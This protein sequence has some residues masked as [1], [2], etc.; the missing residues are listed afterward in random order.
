[1]KIVFD[2]RWV[3]VDVRKHNNALYF[4]ISNYSLGL[5]RAL[6]KLHPVTAL[7]CDKRQLELLP[8]GIDYVLTRNPSSWQEFLLPFKLNKLGADVVF[9]PVKGMVSFGRRYKLMLTIHDLIP[10][11]HRTVPER[12]NKFAQLLWRLFH[13]GYALQR[14]LLARADYVITVSQ[15]AKDELLHYSVTNRPIGVVPNAPHSTAPSAVL[16]RP[17]KT[18][19][20][21]GSFSSY[22][23]VELLMRAMAHLPEYRLVLASYITPR[24]RTELEQLA[25][26]KKQVVFLGG[27]KQEAYN[28]LLASS[29]AL[30]SAS[31]AE[32]FGLPV[33]EAMAQNVPVV[34]SD[35]PIFHEVAG[36]AGTYFDPDAPA[37]FAKAVRTLEDAAVRHRHI[38]AGSYQA[39]KFSWNASAQKLLAIMQTLC[40]R[41]T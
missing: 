31:R 13:R 5:L 27:F 2:A 23:N 24:R 3:V 34:C 9:S 21:V 36:T 8:Q 19:L 22:K 30:V 12:L 38:Q 14:W 25:A 35:I 4:G 39:K 29:F 32:G 20:Y 7:I 15:S 6:V 18:L 1:M 17:G 26:D 37:S 33:I 41:I 40:K 11:Q 10:H 16:P 28:R